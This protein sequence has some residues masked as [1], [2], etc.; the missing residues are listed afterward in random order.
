MKFFATIMAGVALTSA[1]LTTDFATVCAKE[2]DCTASDST[3]CCG[4]F[5]VQYTNKADT[6][7][8]C[9]TEAQRKANKKGYT[10]STTSVTYSWECIETTETG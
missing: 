5:W 1:Q 9:M 10:D 7:L 4:R 6:Y 3:A 8:R 2:A